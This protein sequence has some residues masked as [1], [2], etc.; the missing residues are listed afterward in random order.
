MSQVLYAERSG[1]HVLKFVGDVRLSLSPMISGFLSQ[2]QNTDDCLG[3]VVDLSETETIDSTALGLIAKLGIICRDSFA[4]TLSIVSPKSD[5]TRLL[6]S[7][8][9]Q[10][11]SVI[12]PVPVTSGEKL[13]ELPRQVAS[14]DVL[15]AQVLEAHQVLMGLAADNESRFKDLVMTLEEE[16]KSGTPG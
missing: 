3:V 6:E 9:M 13:E 14:E 10:E 4:Q 2:M 5:I 7:M 8:S 11:V 15:R 12:T 16:Q 1:Y